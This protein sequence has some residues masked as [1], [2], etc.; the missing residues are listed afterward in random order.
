MSAMDEDSAALLKIGTGVDSQL[1]LARSAFVK[2]ENTLRIE[3]PNSNVRL[4][5]TSNIV[6]KS[7]VRKIEHLSRDRLPITNTCAHP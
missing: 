4:R 3:I 5:D 1:C 7:N 2:Y 6:L